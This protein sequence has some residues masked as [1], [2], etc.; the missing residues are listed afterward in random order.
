MRT[1]QPG[2]RTSSFEPSWYV[3]AIFC[4][5]GTTEDFTKACNP[6]P[7]SDFST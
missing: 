3:R 2:A 5:S 7:E 4:L 6:L 1:Y